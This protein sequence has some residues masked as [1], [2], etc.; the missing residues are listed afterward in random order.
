M[1]CQA[2]IASGITK[3]AFRSLGRLESITPNRGID[4]TPGWD[5]RRQTR[6]RCSNPKPSF[7]VNSH[8]H[9][10][11]RSISQLCAVNTFVRL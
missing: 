8:D 4:T 1:P 7:T 5:I 3:F 2:S 6:N 10:E 11:R 9:G